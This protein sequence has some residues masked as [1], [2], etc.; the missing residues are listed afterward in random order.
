MTHPAT[1]TVQAQETPER[2]L[3]RKRLSALMQEVH[4]IYE[5]LGE[6]PKVVGMCSSCGKM[7]LVNKSAA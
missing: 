6:K 4:A 2:V 5:Y 1:D 7:R 3:A